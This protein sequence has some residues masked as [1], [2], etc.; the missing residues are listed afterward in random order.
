M[1]EKDGR[2]GGEKSFYRR[3]HG[4][5]SDRNRCDSEVDSQSIVASIRI[6]A[7]SYSLRHI[8]RVS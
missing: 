2:K 4:A 3:A 5:M 1:Y 6:N 8:S 7:C